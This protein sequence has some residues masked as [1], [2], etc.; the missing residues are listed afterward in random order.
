MKRAGW[1][2]ETVT[3]GDTNLYY[4]IHGAGEPLV[5]IHNFSSNSRDRFAPLLPILTK[6]YTCYLVDLR[7]HGR[8]DN[9]GNIWTKEQ[10]SRDI[11]GLCE[12]LGIS[13][14]HFLAVSSGGMTALRVARYA[15]ALVRTLVIDSATYRVPRESERYYKPPERLKPKLVDYYKGANEIYGADYWKEM[16]QAFY[17]YRLPESDV[18]VALES[19]KEITSPTLIIHGDRDQFFPVDIPAQMKMTIPNSVL[20]IFPDTEHIVMEFHPERVA[21]M[22]ADFFER[23]DRS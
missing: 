15:P 12:K 21:E 17:D 3:V 14:A 8:S 22:A 4:E 11:I 7:G 23:S 10:F 2:G 20:S 18:N 5:C 6:K 9:P 19:L 13:S 1:L 16:A